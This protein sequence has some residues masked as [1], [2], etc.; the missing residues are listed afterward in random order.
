MRIKTMHKTYRGMKSHITAM[1]S[2]N[3]MQSL[4]NPIP[5]IRKTSMTLTSEPRSY[6][7]IGM[8]LR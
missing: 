1:I 6:S 7:P 4:R 2:L 8:G 3:L 5:R